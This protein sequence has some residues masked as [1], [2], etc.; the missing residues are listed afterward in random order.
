[1]TWQLFV[2]VLALVFAALAAAKIPEP[3]RLSFGW[4][5]FALWLVVQIVH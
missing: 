1:M 5:A 2:L 4:A 3:P